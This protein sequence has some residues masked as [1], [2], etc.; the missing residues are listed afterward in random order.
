M[1][2]DS[3]YFLT[4]FELGHPFSN[5]LDRAGALVPQDDREQALG[6]TATQRVRVSVTHGR[7]EDLR[8]TQQELEST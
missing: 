3:R 2:S 8:N 4:W 1:F 5:A 7:G 6:V